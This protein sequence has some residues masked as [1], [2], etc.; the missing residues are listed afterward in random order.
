MKANVI[1]LLAAASVSCAG[2]P[3]AP[4]TSPPTIQPVTLPLPINALCTPV[5]HVVE[6]DGIRATTTRTV[7]VLELGAL[8]HPPAGTASDPHC[9]PR[10]TLNSVLTCLRTPGCGRRVQLDEAKNLFTR[11]GR[12]KMSVRETGG[13]PIGL[14]IDAGGAVVTV[15]PHVNFETVFQN[16]FHAQLDPT[17]S[18]VGSGSPI[19]PRTPTSGTLTSAPT[20]PP[21]PLVATF[22]P[23]C[24][25]DQGPCQCGGS[26]GTPDRNGLTETELTCIDCHQLC[27]R[28]SEVQGG[29]QCLD[30][31]SLQNRCQCGS[32]SP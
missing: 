2:S 19:G 31:T 28:R 29:C 30:D 14:G 6:G 17:L 4:Q 13:I 26:T 24:G 15:D 12:L 22:D 21:G 7:T 11:L 8:F 1:L 18:G 32:T 9:P 25:M 16:L 23:R 5:I 27:L 20:A 10:A 3:D